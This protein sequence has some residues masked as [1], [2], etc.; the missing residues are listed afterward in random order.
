M[1]GFIA[2]RPAVATKIPEQNRP[3]GNIHQYSGKLMPKSPQ[4]RIQ[5]R[6][7]DWPRAEFPENYTSGGSSTN[8]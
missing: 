5:I 2:V 8:F 6:L 1:S 4:F 3:F 7:G